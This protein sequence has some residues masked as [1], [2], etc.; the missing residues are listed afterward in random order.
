MKVEKILLKNENRMIYGG[1]YIPENNNPPVVILCHG[2]AGSR[3]V[4][5][6][7]HRRRLTNIFCE[8]GFA[9]VEFS[10]QGHDEDEKNSEKITP[11]INLKDLEIV[12]EF[13]KKQNF[14]LNKICISGRSYGAYI[15]LIFAS[16]CKEIKVLNLWAPVL[17]FEGVKEDSEYIDKDKLYNYSGIKLKEKF[18]KDG[19]K[20]NLLD[21]VKRIKIPTLIIAVENDEVSSI[22]D[23]KEIYNNLKNPKELKIIKNIGHDAEK[24]LTDDRIKES[25]EWT[26]RWLK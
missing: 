10:F 15:A 13:V 22:N 6:A 9:V 26:K 16:K 20:Y 18:F 19:K 17:N 4:K 8:N 1:I 3:G 7:L 5:Y 2:L 14:D 25:V 21:Y 24:L 11:T 23:V 12:F